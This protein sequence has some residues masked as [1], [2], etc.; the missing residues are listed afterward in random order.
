MIKNNINDVI[1]YLTN[2]DLSDLNELSED[3]DT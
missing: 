3:E 1:E 2:G